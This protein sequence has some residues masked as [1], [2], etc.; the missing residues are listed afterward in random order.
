GSLPVKSTRIVFV[1]PHGAPTTTSTGSQAPTADSTSSL[2]NGNGRFGSC[3]AATLAIPPPNRSQP[4]NART[5][6]RSTGSDPKSSVTLH[7]EKLRRV[8]VQHFA[9]LFGELQNI[10]AVA[11]LNGGLVTEPH[12]LVLVRINKA[13]VR[14]TQSR[15]R[16]AKNVRHEAETFAVP[17]V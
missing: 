15:G 11:R 3:E 4:V 1:L 5:S 9:Q 8:E 13:I 2:G 16:G 6:G 7:H 14:K 10:I 12:E 17:G